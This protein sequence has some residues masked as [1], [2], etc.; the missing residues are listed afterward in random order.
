MELTRH[1]PRI[2]PD[3]SIMR[4]A[5]KSITKQAGTGNRDAEEAGSSQPNTQ[6]LRGRIPSARTVTVD[7]AHEPSAAPFDTDDEAAGRP[8]S[9]AAI[10]EALAHEA[11]T[12]ARRPGPGNFAGFLAA[13]LIVGAAIAFAVLFWIAVR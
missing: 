2:A 10:R 5:K 9:D 1:G 12:P 3:E 8:A 6:Q 11:R 7:S 13:I 4:N